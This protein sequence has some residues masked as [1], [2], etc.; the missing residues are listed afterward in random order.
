MVR[1]TARRAWTFTSERPLF[2]ALAA[3]TAMLALGVLTGRA[4]GSVYPLLEEWF[5][6]QGFFDIAIGMWLVIVGF[7]NPLPSLLKSAGVESG[8]ERSSH[9]IWRAIV[10]TLVTVIGSGSLISLGFNSHG[11]GLAY[12]WIGCV[13]IVGMAGVATWHGVE[14]L[15]ACQ[16]VA[17]APLHVFV[18]SPAETKELRI[19][20]RH[21]TTYA[22]VLTLGY[23]FTLLGTI[24]GGWTGD[25]LR[26]RIVTSFWPVLYIPFCF[27][28]LIYPQIQFRKLILREK[29][30]LLSVCQKGI[31]DVLQKPDL[32]SEDVSRCNALAELFNKI[33]GTPE[34]V[35]D[36]GIVMRYLWIVLVNA[37]TLFLP[38]E[39]LLSMLSD[40]ATR[41]S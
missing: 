24:L 17:S 33:A 6:L 3:A 39:R 18:Y 31:D 32:T 14:I 19:L 5:R 35:I 21:S 36:V 15:I 28:L 34:F 12:L 20:A 2:A 29:E 22:S 27:I 9:D 41:F 4:T 7:S 30:R 13:F 25:P 16:Q 26:V 8:T 11:L 40:Y 23:A 1:E 37:G 38:R 10:I